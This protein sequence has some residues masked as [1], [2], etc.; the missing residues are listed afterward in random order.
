MKKKIKR[1]CWCIGEIFVEK[2]IRIENI[3]CL[4]VWK[5]TVSNPFV[6]HHENH[7]QEEKT[8]EHYLWDELEEDGVATL[9]ETVGKLFK[10]I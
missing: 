9:E 6:E 4:T 2:L 8:Q 1:F 7:V 3:L 5:S 10:I